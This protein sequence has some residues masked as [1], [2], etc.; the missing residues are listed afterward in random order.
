MKYDFTTIIDRKGKDAMALDAVGSQKGHVKKPTL[1]K[2]GFSIIPMWVADMNFATAPSVMDALN[3]RIAHPLF[4]YFYPSDDYYE[5]IMYWQKTRNNIHDLKKEYIGYENG[6]LGCLASAIHA[7]T[8]PGDKILF[9]SPTYVGFSTVL[10]DTDRVVELSPLVKDEEGVWRMDYQDM[11]KRIKD[12]NIRLAVL[13]SPHNPCGRVWEKE[14]L[15]QAMNVFKENDVIVV[16]DEIWSDIVFAGYKHIPTYSI[17]EDAK[18]RT[19]SIYAPSK[20]FNLAGLIGSYHIV[21]DDYLREQLNKVATSTHY[22]NMNVLSMH[23]LI[24]AYR[25]ESIEWV[26]EL[27]QVLEQNMKYTYDFI[28]NNIEGIEVSQT[29]GTYMVFL[30]CED[31]CL[32]NHLTIDELIQKGWDVGVDW[33]SG[34]QFHDSWGIRLNI[35]LPQAL[36]QEAI[37]RLKEYVF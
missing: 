5:A 14:E 29:Q 21:C 12:N 2:E 16:S 10:N 17:S 4:G 28:K 25:E 11:D 24:G 33:Q 7:F 3:K 6:V 8:K 23:A 36:L 20:T 19:I 31:Y 22:N 18:R 27:N 1:P 26:D 37:Q 35:A 13:C 15:E 30:H 32:K 9:H 34:V